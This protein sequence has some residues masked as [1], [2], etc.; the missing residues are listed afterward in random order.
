MMVPPSKPQQKREA[1][2]RLLRK[3]GVTDKVALVGIRGY[4]KNTMGKKNANDLGIYDDGIFLVTPQVYATFNANTDPSVLRPAIATL[5]PGVHRY[6]KGR[7]GISKGAGYP[8]LRPATL[9]NKLPVRRWNARTNDYYYDTGIAINIHKGSYNSTSSAGCQ[10]IYPA[11]WNGFINL[12]Y[13]EMDRYSQ[14]TI[15]YL[16]VEN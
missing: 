5:V 16:L 11:Q 6:R 1:T 10:T 14:K 8:A 15:P 9:G 4:Y 13:S 3:A 12:V 2:E 7:H